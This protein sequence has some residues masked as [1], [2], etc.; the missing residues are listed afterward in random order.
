MLCHNR[1][2]VII[3]AQA[4][5]DAGIVPLSADGGGFSV[6]GCFDESQAGCFHVVNRI[7]D[8][9]YLL[10]QEGKDLLLKLVR[11]YEDVL[12]VEVLT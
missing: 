5:P 6:K 10:N 8:R 2:H 7:Y 1:P 11:A 3:A 12:G 4:W 9:R